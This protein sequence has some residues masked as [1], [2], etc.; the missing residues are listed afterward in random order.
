MK[1]KLLCGVDLGGTKLSIALT[2]EG[3]EIRDKLIVYDHVTKSDREIALYIVDLVK[4]ILKRN[5]LQ[6]ED[7]HGIG[8]C[9]PGHLRYKEGVTIT[10]S[11]LTGF[12][13]FPLRSLIQSHFQTRVILDN[14]ANAQ[15]Y[16]EFCYGA[17]RDY[18]TMIFLTVSSGIG[19][20]IVLNNRIY[21]GMTGTAGEFGHMII[22]PHSRIRC[23]CGNY[24]CLMSCAGGLSLPQV[25][26]KYLEQGV[27]TELELS[28][29]HPMNGKMLSAGLDRHDPLCRMI[30]DEY[31]EYIGTGVYNIF[32]IF[33]PPLIVLGGGFM[34]LG[35]RLLSKIRTRFQELVKDMVCDELKIATS[36]LGDEA[37]SIGAAALV[38]AQ[39]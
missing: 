26:Q 28:D 24:G 18:D 19:G 25:A 9:F 4:Q 17:G 2:D 5:G 7:L 8:V 33:N 21:R 27:G 3:G 36:I 15:T 10:T 22:D 16:A 32:Q 20:G 34:N 35:E 39:P 38:L 1:Q 11:N 29:E 12:K 6:D 23:G 13:N 30:L 14:D 37:G 31:A